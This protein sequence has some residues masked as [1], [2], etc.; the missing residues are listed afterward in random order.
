MSKNSNP[1]RNLLY[2]AIFHKLNEQYV[3]KEFAKRNI[4]ELL[5]EA[6]YASR[7]H[8]R[9]KKI[10]VALGYNTGGAVAVKNLQ[11][12]LFSR[13]DFTRRKSQEFN[14]GMLGALTAADR[15]HALSY[16]TEKDFDFTRGLQEFNAR[17]SEIKRCLQEANRQ[18]SDS[19]VE[20]AAQRVLRNVSASL[21]TFSEWLRVWQSHGGPGY[22]SSL[23]SFSA[24]L[25]KK[26]GPGICSNS[27]HYRVTESE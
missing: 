15:A 12:Y 1:L 2:A 8:S 24:N 4:A 20:L 21:Y 22:V 6:G 10:L 7:D 17:K 25:D 26:F 9:L 11:E 16:V 27:G 3:S 18:L 19:E 23:A 5:A 13:I 14:I